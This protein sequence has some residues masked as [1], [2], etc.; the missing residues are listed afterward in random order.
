MFQEL[1]LLLCDFI[2]TH[3]LA[4]LITLASTEAGQVKKLAY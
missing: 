1:R 2:Q 4:D 3:I